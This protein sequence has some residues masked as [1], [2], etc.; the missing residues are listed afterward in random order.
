M[1]ATTMSAL[2]STADNRNLVRKYRDAVAFMAPVEIPLPESIT[3]AGGKLEALP[4]GWVPVGLVSK[5]GYTF[6]SD[7]S[8]EEVEAL[9]YMEPVRTDITKVEKSIE[10]TSYETMKRQLQELLLGVDLST[11]KQGATGEIIFDEP[12]VPGFKEYRLLIIATD[13]PADSEFI[14][15]RGYPLVK[16]AEIPEEVWSGSDAVAAKIKFD[17]FTDPIMGT[18]CRHYFG[19]TGASKYKDA[20]GYTQGA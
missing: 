4:S 9:G 12:S 15:G 3:G 2:K 20:L 5:D 10:M 17:V 18:S 19:G 11:V 14:V 7:T 8:S 16:L 1:A 6:A 13:G